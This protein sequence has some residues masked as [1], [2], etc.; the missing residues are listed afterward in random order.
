MGHGAY[1]SRTFIAKVIFFIQYMLLD[2][3]SIR[4]N[5]FWPE[6]GF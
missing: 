2:N 1:F 5:N 4:N 3:S 6:T